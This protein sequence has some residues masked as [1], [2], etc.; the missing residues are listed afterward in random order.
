[1]QE[2]SEPQGLEKIRQT[3]KKLAW[4]GMKMIVPRYKWR[5]AIREWLLV[6]ISQ[7]NYKKKIRELSKSKDKVKVVFLVSENDKWNGDSLYKKLDTDRRFTPIVLYVPL[8]SHL[9]NISNDSINRQFFM[10]RGYSFAVVTNVDDLREHKPDI[11]FY[12]QPWD[13]LDGDLTPTNISQYALCLYFPYSIATTIEHQAIW[14]SCFLFFKTLYCHFVFNI[15]VVEQ[16]N[17]KG[18]YNIIATGHPKMDAYIVPINANPWKNTKKFKIVYAPHHSFSNTSLHW[19]TFG[20][21]GRE[22]LEWAKAHT[23][24]EWIFKPHPLFRRA[25]IDI[26]IMSEDEINEYYNEW[27][28]IGAI[29]DQ[30]D[31]FDIFRT[32]DLLI[33]DCGSFLTEW[34]PTEKPCIHLLSD[35]GAMKNR[36][37]VHEKSSMHYYKVRNLDELDATIEMLAVHREDPLAEARVQDAKTI[38]L[39]CAKNIHNWLIETLWEKNEKMFACNNLHNRS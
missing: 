31:Y 2:P 7:R 6:W 16:F 3:I 30:G 19:A 8:Y 36:S 13:V 25:V 32:A 22:L 34:L 11:V 18:L 24:T 38:P 23:D 14:N 37:F 5:R 35:N 21:N 12:Q 27:N 4:Q 29:Y 9:N 10:E 20:W 17:I 39:D 26:D 33:T 1:M 28:K 15:G